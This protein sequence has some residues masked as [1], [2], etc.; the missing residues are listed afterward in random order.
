MRIKLRLKL[1]TLSPEAGM[2]ALVP[3]SPCMKKGDINIAF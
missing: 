3:D 2:V 1:G